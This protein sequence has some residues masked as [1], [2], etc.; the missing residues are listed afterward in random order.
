[1]QT[2]ISRRDLL[3]KCIALGV[4]TCASGLSPSIVAEGWARSEAV[5]RPPTPQAVLGPFY[6][7]LAPSTKDLRQPGDPGMLLVVKGTVFSTRGETLPGANVE[8]WQANH[9]GHYDLDGYHYR[10][11]LTSSA[12]GEY[13]F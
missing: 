6:K 4:V 11:R 10:T 7:R 2:R 5:P 1:M 3:E 9:V 13:D 12:E 8:V